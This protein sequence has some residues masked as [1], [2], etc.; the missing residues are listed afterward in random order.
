DDC[1][2]RLSAHLP[3]EHIVDLVLVVSFY[4]AV[5]LVV[6]ALE[7]DLE[8]GFADQE[9]LFDDAAT[10]TGQAARGG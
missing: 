2:G 1:F 6:G 5:A 10:R 7:V 3:A 9:I 8:P 4:T